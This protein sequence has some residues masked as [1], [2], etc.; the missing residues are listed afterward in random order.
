LMRAQAGVRHVLQEIAGDGHC[1]A[2][3]ENLVE[4]AATLLEIPAPIIE[5]AIAE[6]L[7]QENLVAEPIQEKPALFLT[8]LYRSERGIAQ[9]IE[10]LAGI[11]SWGRIEPAKAIPWVEEKTGLSLSESQRK[12]VAQAVNGKV[13]VITGGPGVGGI[14]EPR[15]LLWEC[16]GEGIVYVDGEAWAGLDVAHRRCRLPK[17]ARE[18]LIEMATYQTAIWTHDAVIPAT[19]PCYFRSAEVARRDQTRWNIYWDLAVLYDLLQ[20]RLSE[21]NASPPPRE[22]YN[23]VHVSLAPYTRQ[24]LVALDKAC[25]LFDNNA[26]A[27]LGA[28]LKGRYDEFSGSSLDGRVNVVGHAHIDLVWLWPE[29]ET[30]RKAEHTFSTVLRLMEEY[31][32]LIFQHSSPLLYRKLRSRNPHLS[33]AVSMR[34]EE[35]RWERSGAMELES[36]VLLTSGEGLARSFYF[37]QQFFKEKNGSY[38]Q[39]LWLPDVFGYPACLPQLMRLGGVQQFYTTKLYWS[40]ITRFPHTI[41]RWKGP[42]RS[43]VVAYLSPVGYDNEAPYE[44]VRRAARE[45]RQAGTGAPALL[46]QGWGDGGGGPTE[47]MCERLRRLENLAGA[48]RVAWKRA[49]ES[50]QELWLM[51]HQFPEYQGELYLEC[52]RG[53]ATSQKRF[54]RAIRRLERRTLL[55]EGLHVLFGREPLPYERW[56]RLLFSQFHDAVPGSSIG[57]TFQQLQN[58]LETEMASRGEEIEAFTEGRSEV[59]HSGAEDRK[60]TAEGPAPREYLLFNPLPQERIVTCEEPRETDL[61]RFLLDRGVESQDSYQGTVL[62]QAVTPGF[63]AW[64]IDE[65]QLPPVVVESSEDGSV[66]I[67]NGRIDAAILPGSASVTLGFAD[68]PEYRLKGSLLAVKDDPTYFDA[69]DIDQFAGSAP[70]AIVNR[71]LRVLESGPI[72]GRVEIDCAVGSDSQ[73]V[74]RYDLHRGENAL[75]V[76]LDGDWREKH[77]LLQYSLNTPKSW[78]SG[79]LAEAF[80]SIRRSLALGSRENNARW[81]ET[82]NLWAA[83]TDESEGSGVSMV[84]EASYGFH[85]EPGN[86]RLSLLRSPTDPDPTCDEGSQ[87]VRFAVGPYVAERRKHTPATIAMP[88]QLYAEYQLLP[89]KQTP[90]NL[91]TLDLSESVLASVVTPARSTRGFLL[92]LQEHSGAPGS[93][94]IELHGAPGAPRVV[95]FL[96]EPTEKE[97]ESSGNGAWHLKLEPHEIVTLLVPAT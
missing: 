38:S 30:Y 31:P 46:A 20:T 24:L 49:D 35:G 2:Y 75:R 88:E 13:T 65:P 87:R 74:L 26:L 16:D 63:G 12:A 83:V 10:R 6:E 5:Q 40:S 72:R 76:E 85:R 60:G 55:L 21:E 28:Y 67:G 34:A 51:R 61:M 17:G 90:A 41:F 43:E 19:R 70:V 27:E 54:K 29:E 53:T 86:M 18:V 81:E 71:N 1:A 33:E 82:G 77:T 64:S 48:P 3:R 89:S 66:R 44:L 37:G 80:E 32:E 39:L 36:D 22:G 94:G 97:I 91:F 7:A 95:D 58:D 57:I 14:Q 9:D 52:H 8:P 11:P 69:W 25:D 96:E 50:M 47:A 56:E 15:H 84:A 93:A 73:F 78:T 92:R 23:E 4:S 62:F 45:N 79:R 42:D 59:G 68:N